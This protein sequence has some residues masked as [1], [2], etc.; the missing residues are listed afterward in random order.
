MSKQPP[1]AP[2]LP[3][4]SLKVTANELPP[5]HTPHHDEWL[6]DEALADT[7]PG[8]DPIAVA[9]NAPTTDEAV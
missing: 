2:G 7:F 6:L 8:T 1:P 9:P 4:K 5:A 3:A